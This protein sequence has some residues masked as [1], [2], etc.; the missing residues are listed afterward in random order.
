MHLRDALLR[1]LGE[2][3]AAVFVCDEVPDDRVKLGARRT[4]DGVGFLEYLDGV[5]E[6]VHSRA[7]D[8]RAP[9]RGGLHRVR[10]VEAAERAADDGDVGEFVGE[11]QLADGV[12]EEER[13]GKKEGEGEGDEDDDEE[14]QNQSLE[15]A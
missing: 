13:E 11:T 15:E 12:E 6:V 8:E 14:K 9:Q 7:Y 2:F 4:D 5:E 1:I 3:V 10:A